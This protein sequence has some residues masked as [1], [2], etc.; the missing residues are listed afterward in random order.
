MAEVKSDETL[1][2]KTIMK[3]DDK[4][5]VLLGRELL[6]MKPYNFKP[7]TRDSGSAWTAVA[8]DLNKVTEVKFDVTQKSV[9]DRT[10]IAMNNHKRKMRQQTAE[11][12]SVE[13]PTEMDQVWEEISSEMQEASEKHEATSSNKKKEEDKYKADAEAIR[14]TAMETHAETRKRKAADDG[15]PSSS[16]GKRNTGTETFSFLMAKL[17]TD[18][19]TKDKELEMKK[20]TMEREQQ[21][22]QLLIEQ[23]KQIQANQQQQNQI[24]L[25]LIQALSQMN[26]KNPSNK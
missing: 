9:R 10:K 1:T 20:M 21:Q 14:A 3:W 25:Q 2:K 22:L 16:K 19:E 24:S 12:G 26:N 18:K 6:F 7:G 17:E 4:H 13:N 5:D 23:Q 15:S 11:S 8:E